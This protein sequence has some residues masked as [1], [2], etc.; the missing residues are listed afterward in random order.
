MSAQRKNTITIIDNRTGK[1]VEVPVD[2]HGAVQGPKLPVRVFD[3]AYLNTAVARSK[4]SMVDGD[5]GILEYRGYPI[6]QLAERS[7]FVECAY[8]VLF[9]ELPTRKQFLEF[10]RAVMEGSYLPTGAVKV[11]QAFNYDS[12]PMSI[13][14][15]TVGSLGAFN[16]QA[17]PAFRGQDLFRFPSE[18]RSQ[19]MMKIVGQVMTIGAAI[20]RHRAGKPINEPIP[21]L[22]LAEN[23]LHMWWHNSGSP[24]PVH[25]GLARALDVLFILHADHEMNCST[26]AIRHVGSSLVDPYSAVAGATAA[27]Y[28]PLHGGANEAVV[29]MLESIGN[30]KN[31]PEFIE[32][33]KQKKKKLMGFGHRIYKNFDPRAKLVQRTAYEVFDIVGREPLIDVAIALSEA[34]LKDEYF[35]SRKLYPNVDFFSGLIYRAMGFPTDFFPVLFAMPRTVGWLAHWSEGMDVEGAQIWRPRQ[36]FIGEKRRDYVAVEARKEVP[37]I[38]AK[39]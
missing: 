23:F 10:N 6:E 11:I 16:P 32:G 3:P 14:L 2:E 21:E 29:R 22:S 37:P 33:V 35:V 30:V 36:L 31:V 5:N 28:G 12:H 19:T 25:P 24:K 4:I 13:F 15:S 1:Q 20:L 39:I 26:A 38:K 18:F 17:N 8:L 27:L 34:A 7:N 9:G